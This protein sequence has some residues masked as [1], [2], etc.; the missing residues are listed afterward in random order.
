MCVILSINLTGVIDLYQQVFINFQPSIDGINKERQLT[1]PMRIRIGG[2]FYLSL[3]KLNPVFGEHAS[4]LLYIHIPRKFHDVINLLKYLSIIKCLSFNF[5]LI[6]STSIRPITVQLVDRLPKLVAWHDRFT[7]F[8]Y[9][10]DVKG[11]IS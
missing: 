10:I 1:L 6:R 3:G 11:D 7:K 9:G 8:I 5:V 2:A 4:G